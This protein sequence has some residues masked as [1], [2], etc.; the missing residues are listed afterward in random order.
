MTFKNLVL[1]SAAQCDWSSSYFA[2]ADHRTRDR[3]WYDRRNTYRSRGTVLA[4][5]LMAVRRSL[6]GISAGAATS[7]LVFFSPGVPFLLFAFAANYLPTGYSAVLNATVPFVLRVVG[8]AGWSATIRAKNSLA[9][10]VGLLG[11]A[12]LVRFAP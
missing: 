5:V 8:L 3:H 9:L 12:T 1:L 7:R 2:P 6:T 4:G 11:V 10:V